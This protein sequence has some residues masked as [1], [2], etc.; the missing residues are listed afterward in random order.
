MESLLSNTTFGGEGCGHLRVA[1]AASPPP[2]LCRIATTPHLRPC[3]GQHRSASLQQCLH[4]SLDLT[5]TRGCGPRLHSFSLNVLP[6]SDWEVQEPRRQCEIE[7]SPQHL[8][9]VAKSPLSF[10]FKV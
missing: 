1:T 9:S 4:R 7:H 6:N 8:L 2:P 3:R 10:R 5:T